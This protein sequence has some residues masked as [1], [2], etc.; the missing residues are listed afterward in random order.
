MISRP[1]PGPADNWRRAGRHHVTGV[2]KRRQIEGK[3]GVANSPEKMFNRV[4]AIFKISNHQ[5][6]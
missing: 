1:I 2:P 5:K 3:I 4:V 6:I